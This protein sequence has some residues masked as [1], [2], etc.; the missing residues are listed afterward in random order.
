MK[1]LI[2]LL[3]AA[4]ASFAS[5]ADDAA[6]LA[7]CEFQMARGVCSVQLDRTAYGPTVTHVFVSRR[8][9]QL[10]AMLML[11]ATDNSMCNVARLAC[12]AGAT[13]TSL[14]QDICHIARSRWKP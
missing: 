7:E 4:L 13:G 3:V 2:L 9:V 12:A 10:D 6:M 14:Q 8:K 11:R 5:R 1:A